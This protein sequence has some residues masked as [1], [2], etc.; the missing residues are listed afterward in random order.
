[1]L[2][3][4]VIINQEKP[5]LIDFYADWCAPCQWLTPI[6]AEL[7]PQLVGKAE[8]IKIDIDKHPDLAK[9]YG[10]MSVP[11]L[12]IFKKGEIVWRMSGFLMAPDLL[13]VLE[14]FC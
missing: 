5:I 14:R 4:N 2:D 3:F 1:M 11:T 8:I 10:V 6:L 12:I 13:R 9:Q 7:E